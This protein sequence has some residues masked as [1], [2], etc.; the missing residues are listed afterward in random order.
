MQGIWCFRFD[1]ASMAPKLQRILNNHLINPPSE[2]ERLKQVGSRAKGGLENASRTLTGQP[3]THGEL[4]GSLT[5]SSKWIMGVQNTFQNQEGCLSQASISDKEI[6][7]TMCQAL[8]DPSFKGTVKHKFPSFKTAKGP[9]EHLQCPSWLHIIPRMYLNK[10]LT[11]PAVVFSRSVFK[12]RSSSHAH[13]T[14]QAM[15]LTN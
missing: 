2:V 8:L 12:R 9:L 3:L 11:V 13:G 15:K 6:R 5:T 10:I 1:D 14:Q 7:R 4:Y